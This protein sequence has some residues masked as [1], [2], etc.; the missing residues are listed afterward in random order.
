MSDH[1][2]LSPAH[3]VVSPDP[4]NRRVL[5]LLNLLSSGRRFFHALN[6]RK[7]WLILVSSPLETR[8]KTF[9]RSWSGPD[10]TGRRDAL[11]ADQAASPGVHS[12]VEHMDFLEKDLYF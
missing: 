5:N 3:V 4:E 9:V 6:E 2:C 11:D 1:N 10:F 8:E 7:M 12:G